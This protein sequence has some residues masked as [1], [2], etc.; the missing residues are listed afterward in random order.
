MASAGQASAGG[1]AF[2]AGL[3]AAGRAGSGGCGAAAGGAGRLGGSLAWGAGAPAS[4]DAGELTFQ[5]L[6]AHLQRFGIGAGAG[7]QDAG[8]HQLEHQ[9]RADRVAHLDQAVVQQLGS[10]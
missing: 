10:A 3:G 5:P 1:S 6:E 9:A 4:P 2:G 8:E 7:Q